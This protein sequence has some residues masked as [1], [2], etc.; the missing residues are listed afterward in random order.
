MKDLISRRRKAAAFF[1]LPR[2]TFLSLP[3]SL[4]GVC[5]GKC[6]V[7]GGAFDFVSVFPVGGDPGGGTGEKMETGVKSV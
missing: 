3:S 7:Y 2:S 1:L 4:P 5:G 6:S